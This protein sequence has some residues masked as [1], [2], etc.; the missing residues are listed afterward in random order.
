VEEL[1]S[2]LGEEAFEAA[3]SEGRAMTPE[4]AIKY[5]LSEEEPSTKATMSEELPAG[6]ERPV[7]LTPRERE[8]A[9]LVARELTNR[10]IAEELVISERTVATHVHKIL[11]KL[12]FRS[13]LQIAAWAMEQNLLR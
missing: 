12:N 6:D 2:R 9:M 4:Q 7:A 3:W 10:R 5:A 8:V 1:R 13:R 11:E